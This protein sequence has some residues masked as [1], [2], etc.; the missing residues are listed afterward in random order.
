MKKDALMIGDKV[1]MY[2]GKGPYYR[3]VVSDIMDNGDIYVPIPTIKGIPIIL[4]A[5][6]ELVLLYYRD[7]GR[8]LLGCKVKRMIVEGALRQIILSVVAG[9]ERQ[10]RRTSFRV[11]TMLR[12]HIK[13]FEEGPFERNIP[14]DELDELTDAHTLNISSTGLAI[15]TTENYKI[16]D[17]LYILLYLDWPT[18]NSPPMALQGE[19]RQITSPSP[20]SELNQVGIRLVDLSVEQSNH[21]AKFVMLEEQRRVRQNRLVEGK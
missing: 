18:E 2:L 12:S 14:E 8:F 20:G 19:V 16:G 3:T 1:D 15:R 21:I 10:Q 5:G 7:N 17:L 11:S 4:S 13:T 9:P 6:Q